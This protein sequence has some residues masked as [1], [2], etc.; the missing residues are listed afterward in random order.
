MQPETIRR[1]NDINR[2]F[3]H[4]T[5]ADFDATRQQS[6][7]GW[8]RLLPHLH[9]RG[10][11]R[12]LVLDV[13]CGNGRF[14]LFLAQHLQGQVVYHG[15]DSSAALLEQA[16]ESLWL[17]GGLSATLEQRDVVEQPP[18]SGLYDLVALFG[19]VH[20]IPGA[21]HRL[22]W[23]RQMA[24]RVALG[25]LLVFAAWRFYEYERFRE[26]IV[27]WPDNLQA[28]SYDYLLDWRRGQT[29]LRYCHYV[30]DA[31]H[32]ELVAAT[33][34]QEIDTYRADGEGGALNC[35]SVLRK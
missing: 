11:A 8:E 20:H 14:G 23:L 16:D 33:G 31:E 30:D 12:L 21:Q 35:Y 1:L 34:L 4:I 18:T 26:H 5:A 10:D 17:H 15:L 7:P 32:A 6:W 2:R 13:G 3:Y 28:E 29:A 25:G 24:Q 22:Q 19:L 9:R 27:P